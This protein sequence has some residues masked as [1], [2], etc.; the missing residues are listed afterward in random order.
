MYKP[1]GYILITTAVLMS[2]L[3]LFSIGLVNLAA[4]ARG[5]EKKENFKVITNTIAE[6][7]LE[8]AIWCL[9]QTSGTNCGE[10]YGSNYAGETNA[11]FGGGIYDTA[12]TAVSG[13]VKLIE[14]TAYYPNKTKTLGK[15]V[16]RI[17]AAIATDKV[18]FTYGVQLGQGGFKMEENS[19]I[20]GSIY[21]L[22]TIDG[23]HDATI[24]GDAFVAAGA[25]LSPDQ[26]DTSHDADLIFGKTDPTIDLT[27]SFTPSITEFLNKISF[28]IKR[29]SSAP[30]N[31]S[32]KIVNNDAGSGSDSPGSTVLGSATLDASLVSTSFGW[33]DVVFNS[34]SFLYAGT[35]YWIILDA[36]KNSTRYW[37]IGVDAFDNYAGG[38]MFNSQGWPSYPWNASG[39][40]INFKTWSGGVPAEITNI[41]IN[42]NVFAHT[43]TNVTAGGNLT[44][45]TIFEGNVT[46]NTWA[47]S[48]DS[49]TIGKNATSTSIINSTVGQSLWCQTKSGT[50]VGW[51]THCPYSVTPPTDPGPVNMPISDGLIQGWKDDATAG[52]PPFNGD[53]IISSNASL[54]PQKIIGNLTVGIGKTLTVTGTIYVTGDI[55][56]DNNSIINLDSSYGSSSG[57]II[58]D[59]KITMN[60]GSIFSGAGTGSYLLLVSTKN[61]TINTAIDVNNASVSAIVYAPYGIIDIKNN[62]TLVEISAWKIHADQRVVLDYQSGLADINFSSGPTGG[63]SRVKGSWVIIE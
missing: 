53:K 1:R 45:Y 40:D 57:I 24:T 4:T 27:Q 19:R 42:G 25:A 21:S 41:T 5:V 14:S 6:A 31:I 58:A 22:G 56:F 15:T 37:T 16:M 9:N 7:G 11:A 34:P 18:S 33:V 32:V 2:V 47:N 55:L 62:A 39:K 8:K 38:T 43:A 36:S 23:D 59:G 29:T 52:G 20:N 10:T 49:S 61:D 50:T 28:Y 12:L 17:R 51:A 3:L 48:I 60:N 35:K 13:S 63:W 44:A 54:G 46:G 30:G 26:Q